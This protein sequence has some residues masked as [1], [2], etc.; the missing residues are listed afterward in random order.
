VDIEAAHS[1]GEEDGAAD[2]TIDVVGTIDS[3]GNVDS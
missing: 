2:G 1:V 3:D